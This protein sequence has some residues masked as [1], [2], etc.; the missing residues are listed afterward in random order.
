MTKTTNEPNEIICECGHDMKDHSIVLFH[1][2]ENGEL[3]PC[4]LDPL[5]VPESALNARLSTLEAAVEERDETIE[6]LRNTL[7]ICFGDME[8]CDTRKMED[9]QHIDAAMLIADTLAET[10][11]KVQ[12]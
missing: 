10:A 9:A 7:V 12:S 11:P 6:K 1:S 5:Q 8:A 2:A 3:C 4:K